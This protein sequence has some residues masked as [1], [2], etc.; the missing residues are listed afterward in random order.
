MLFSQCDA[1][2][3]H[4]PGA[5]VVVGVVHEL[6]FDIQCR[7]VCAGATCSEVQVIGPVARMVVGGDDVPEVPIGG[8]HPIALIAGPSGAGIALQTW[9]VETQQ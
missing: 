3:G 4:G 8:R 7:R 6:Q 1:V 9:P 2:Q 5:V